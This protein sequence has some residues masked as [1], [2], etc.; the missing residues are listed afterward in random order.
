MYSGCVRHIVSILSVIVSTN[1]YCDATKRQFTVADDVGLVQFGDPYTAAA[2][3]ITF[4]PDRQYFVVN[5]QR[6]LLDRN[7][8]ESSLGLFRTEDVRHF[9]IHVES[10]TRP[11]P[12]WVIRRSTYKDGPIITDIRW[13]AD[14]SGVAFLAKSESGDNQ[15]F[16]AGVIT[17]IVQAL[18]PVAH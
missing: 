11:L 1:L 14:G 18:S 6:G 5:T 10:S 12:I 16:L 8:P 3:A 17:K 15:L 9:L 4:S 7:R 2:E 13:L